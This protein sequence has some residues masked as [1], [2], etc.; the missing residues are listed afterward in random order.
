MSTTP[1]QLRDEANR[2]Y[3]LGRSKRSLE[4]LEE[5]LTLAP[6]RADLL[7]RVSLRRLEM[8]RVREGVAALERALELDPER[9]LL[10]AEFLAPVEDLLSRRPTFKNLVKLRKQLL[11][12]KPLRLKDRREES[13]ANDA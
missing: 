12:G 8:A 10:Q 6:E 13:R 3:Q 1:D 4:L 11:E 2:S 7:Y 9:S 5:A